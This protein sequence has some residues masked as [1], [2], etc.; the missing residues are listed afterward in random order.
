MSNKNTSPAAKHEP[1]ATAE[2]KHATAN[3]GKEIP[4]QDWTCP[5]GSI[6]T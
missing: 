2:S 3:K 6:G 5:E 1:H 4:K